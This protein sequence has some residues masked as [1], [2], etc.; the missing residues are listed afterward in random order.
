MKS[1]LGVP[2]VADGK[3]VGVVSVQNKKNAEFSEYDQMMLNSIANTIASLLFYLN[4]IKHLRV[5]N[6][7]L[8][9]SRWELIRSRNTLRSL[10]DNLPDSLYIIDQNY[11]LVAINM[12]RAM[13]ADREPRQ[14]VGALCYEALYK[15]NEP[16]PGC[17]VGETFFEK[18][19]THRTGRQWDE[20]N[21]PMEWEISTYPIIDESDHV[22]QVILFEQDVTEKHRLETSLAQS[23]KMAAVGQ[24]AAGIAH[25][26]NNPLTVVL[27]NA[28]IL[29]RELPEDHEAQ[30]S[31]D[32]IYRAG[33]RALHVV[34]NLLN[35]ARKEQY[36]FIP[37]DINSTIERALEMLKHELLER[38]IE[39]T[40]D[41]ADNLPLVMAS[42]D[43]LQGVWLNI[44]LNAMD[45]TE[46]E[47]GRLKVAT[48]QQGNEVRVMISDNGQGISQDALKRIF[49]PFFTT[50]EP[51]R[52]TGLGLS[53]C[54]RIV[55]QHGGHILVDSMP[56]KGTTF[57]VVLPV[58]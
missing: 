6:A 29:Q 2:L 12:S 47:K 38:S 15:R 31:V 19:N 24:L 20:G 48:M 46:K 51:G 54:H 41:P 16:C 56:G 50:K 3:V 13:R 43:H 25:E 21:D 10:F 7:H 36:E 4:S 42:A 23:E 44:L 57:T 1:F 28:Q 17:L 30:E 55:K 11:Q 26:I 33:S 39:L 58:F 45:A 22:I 49:E 32:L 35:F 40:Y 53:L 27:A 5:M 34:R 14:L 18:R 37:T 8:E 9:A 52:G